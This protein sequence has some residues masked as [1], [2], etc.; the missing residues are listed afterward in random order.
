MTKRLPISLALGVA[1]ALALA[2]CSKSGGTTPAASAPSPEAGRDAFTKLIAHTDNMI[3]ILQDNRA[4][5]GKATRELT[6]YQEE[7][8][9]EIEQLKQAVGDSMQRDPMKWA[10][11]ASVYGMKSAQLDGLTAEVTGKPRPQ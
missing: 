3:K 1:L 4:D 2:A 5:P 9:A 8:K 11:A 10:A 7:H 6:A